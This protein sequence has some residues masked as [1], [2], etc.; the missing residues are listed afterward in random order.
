M[1]SLKTILLIA[2]FVVL[3]A[4]AFNVGGL[5]MWNGIWIAAAL[6]VAGNLIPETQQQ[7]A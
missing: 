7:A 2:A 1:S 4:G 3:M 5:K 6:A